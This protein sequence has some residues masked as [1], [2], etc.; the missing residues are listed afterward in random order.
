MVHVYYLF[1]YTYISFL[2]PLVIYC[3][4]LTLNMVSV[5]VSSILSTVQFS[6]LNPLMGVLLRYGNVYSKCVNS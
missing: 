3:D 1:R 4:F 6:L 5:C 2:I